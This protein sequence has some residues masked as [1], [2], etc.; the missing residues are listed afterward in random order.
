[1]GERQ[2]LRKPEAPSKCTATTVPNFLLGD[3]PG[4]HS[5]GARG[6]HQHSEVWERGPHTV[7]SLLGDQ[8]GLTYSWG[9]R[10]FISPCGMEAIKQKVSHTEDSPG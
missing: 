9:T 1:M 10:V 8:L 2:V 3:Q 6:I 7:N 5:G 4:L